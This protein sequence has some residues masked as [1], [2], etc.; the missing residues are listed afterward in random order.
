[1]WQLV[2][3]L[4]KYVCPISTRLD[5][6]EKILQ[7]NFKVPSGQY[8]VFSD[9]DDHELLLLG[10]PG[11]GDGGVKTWVGWGLITWWSWSQ[12]RAPGPSSPRC[13]RTHPWNTEESVLV[14]TTWKLETGFF[15]RV[16]IQTKVK[17]LG[18]DLSFEQRQN[19][20]V[21]NKLWFLASENIF[22]GKLVI[23]L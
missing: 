16:R 23:S 3:I 5:A 8:D 4:S 12:P 10:W 13:W 1:M 2:K 7:K 19:I 17:D 22:F 20:P 11:G 9:V 21:F 18:S 15:C 14:F 6:R